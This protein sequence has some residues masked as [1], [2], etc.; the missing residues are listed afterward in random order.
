MQEMFKRSSRY[1]TQI[2]GWIT[3]NIG[4]LLLSLVL[5]I[6]VWIGANQSLDPVEA[7][8]LSN[9]V[10]IN[11]EG[12]GSDLQIVNNYPTTTTVQ[13]RA[14]RDTWLSISPEDILVTAD[15]TGLGP[16]VHQ[17]PLQ[18]EIATRA[19]LLAANPSNI[20]V[21]IEEV[22]ERS[23]P[24]HLSMTG[25]PVTGFKAEHA[26]ITPAEVTVRGPRSEVELVSDIRAEVSIEGI[27]ETFVGE[28]PVVALDSEGNPVPNVQLTPTLV[29][30]NVPLATG[31]GV[32]EVI[33]RVDA[34]VRPAPGYYVARYLPDPP[35]VTIQGDPD[36]INEILAIETQPII[37]NNVTEDRVVTVALSPPPNVSVLDVQTVDVQIIVAAQPGFDVVEVPV[38][39]VGLAEGLSAE[40]S[41]DGVIVTLSGPLPV[42]E[43]LDLQKDILV[44]VDLSD[45]DAGIYQIEPK[46]EIVS[47]D[48]PAEELLDVLIESVS[49]TLIDVEIS[50][51][52]SGSTNN[53]R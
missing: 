27:R 38:Q 21:E 28:L 40:F 48:V 49:P 3:S 53:P 26:T 18:V 47:S 4:T 23:L 12:L 46:A 33:V 52:L 36:T 9:P 11:V 19:T 45:R 1:L 20:Q 15:L 37:L 14:Q 41:P 32:R 8:E 6:T 13:L 2:A 44:T 51:S 30:V 43:R 22:R 16:G 31:E 10:A 29:E 50:A 17:V 42:L 7:G 25:E 39:A 35:S 24:V 34:D 5:S